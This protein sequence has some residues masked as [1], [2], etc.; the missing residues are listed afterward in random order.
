MIVG[1]DQA[2]VRSNWMK[3]RDKKKA[4]GQRGA[5][6]AE[7]DGDR[8]PCVHEYWYSRK[9]YNDTEAIPR[10]SRFEELVSAI[11]SKGRVIMQ[12]D[13]PPR[14]NS[15]GQTILERDGYIDVFLVDAIEFDHHGLRF[16]V[17]ERL[18]DLV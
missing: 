11:R 9:N 6:F 18:C 10:N 7:A 1:V 3:V 4:V 13:K 14:R 15:E 2:L 12:K 16:R 8:L 17:T 5:W